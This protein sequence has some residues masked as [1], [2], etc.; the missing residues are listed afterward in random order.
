M[1]VILCQSQ[2][3]GTGSV[4]Y[5]SATGEEADV[6]SAA[7]PAAALLR[8]VAG[9]QAAA[10]GGGGRLARAVA[11]GLVRS[12]GALAVSRR[13]F[14]EGN[15]TALGWCEELLAASAPSQRGEALA[16]LAVARGVAASRG[17]ALPLQ[18]HGEAEH[19]PLLLVS[20]YLES[21]DAGRAIRF[22]RVVGKSVSECSFRAGLLLDI[23]LPADAAA[24]LRRLYRVSTTVAL[25]SCALE[26]GAGERDAEESVGSAVHGASWTP[27]TSAVAAAR[28]VSLMVRLRVAMVACQRGIHPSLRAALL[29]AHILPLERL[30][31][32]HLSAFQAVS[33]ALPVHEADASSDAIRRSLGAVASISTA[34]LF[35]TRY[36]WLRG[37]RVVT[38]VLAAPDEAALLEVHRLSES[39]TI[40]ERA[41]SCTAAN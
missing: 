29:D 26:P 5:R 40:P 25:F 22:A 38:V 27:V 18:C 11:T 31:A 39:A 9:Q 33:G 17:G 15:A 41:A 19:L 23:P 36:V 21:G 20:A 32:R 7:T 30:S 24:A 35:E 12:F 14:T 6:G 34:Y 2:L 16:L 13:C 37:A 8:Q 1:V 4:G 3:G 10:H 28:F